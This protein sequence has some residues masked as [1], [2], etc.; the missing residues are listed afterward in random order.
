MGVE[1]NADTSTRWVI[2]GPQGM[3]PIYVS[4]EFARQSVDDLN[5]E[6][7]ARHSTRPYWCQAEQEPGC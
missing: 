4:R 6:H 3:I 7:E 2:Y 1:T 5:D